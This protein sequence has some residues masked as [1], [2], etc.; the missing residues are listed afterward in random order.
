[1]AWVIDFHQHPSPGVHEFMAQHHINV[2][3][4]LP[5]P[6]GNQTV[7]AWAKKWPGR[8]VPFYWVDLADTERAADELEVAVTRQGHKGIK[9]QPL[10]HI[11][12]QY[13]LSRL[14][15]QP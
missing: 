15:Q 13:A 5:G 9:F 11:R 7:L 4:L 6:G 12:V 10:V 1:M 8:F 3:V 2:S 14:Q